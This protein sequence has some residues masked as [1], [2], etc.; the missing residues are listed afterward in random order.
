[1]S[2]T[3][4]E[5]TRREV[6]LHGSE[7]REER[8]LSRPN[9]SSAFP[10]CCRQQLQRVRPGGRL[11]AL[12]RLHARERRMR[13]H[14]HHWIPKSPCVTPRPGPES[15]PLPRPSRRHPDEKPCLGFAIYC[16]GWR[17][18]SAVCLAIVGAPDT[19]RLVGVAEAERA[20]AMVNGSTEPTRGRRSRTR[21]GVAVKRAADASGARSGVRASQ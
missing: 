3:P 10:R 17:E 21:T 4:V 9:E 15:P 2:A 8:F 1:M 20:P 13:S 12:R 7:V 6:S 5:N 19:L 16:M 18:L 11:E 14:G